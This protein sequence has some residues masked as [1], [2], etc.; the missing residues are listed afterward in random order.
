MKHLHCVLCAFALLLLPACDRKDDDSNSYES[1][2]RIASYYGVAK[3]EG[4]FRVL[5]VCSGGAWIHWPTVSG[6]DYEEGFE[7][8]I[9]VR[10]EP[11]KNPP[12]GGSSFTMS[13]I[14][15]ISKV[16]KQTDDCPL[17]SWDEFI[18]EHPEHPEWAL[19]YE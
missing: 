19:R 9:K 8:E 4:A 7:Y 2:G 3:G 15:V 5:N 11:V 1:M 13:L 17:Q 14:K 10:V 18:A 16:E 6:L 12:M